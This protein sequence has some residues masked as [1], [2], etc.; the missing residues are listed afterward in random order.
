MDK[1]GRFCIQ[2][3]DQYGFTNSDGTIVTTPQYDAVSLIPGKDLAIVENN[4][5]YGIID[6]LGNI[7]V[8]FIYHHLYYDY[9]YAAKRQEE[10]ILIATLDNKEGC[11]NVTDFSECIP[12]IYDRVYGYS[13]NRLVVKQ[14]EN[15]WCN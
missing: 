2:K 15:V 11:L 7:K 3:N 6:F 8:P 4:G 12:I 10:G 1:E 9:N 5:L 13:K 14:R